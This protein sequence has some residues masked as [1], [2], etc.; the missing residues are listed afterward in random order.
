MVLFFVTCVFSK[1]NAQDLQEKL[2]GKWKLTT[3]EGYEFFISSFA[4]QT[5]P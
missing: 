1:T 4:A 5:R 3:D 2:L